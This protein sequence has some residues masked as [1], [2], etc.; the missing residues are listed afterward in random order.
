LPSAALGII[1]VLALL[2]F[3]LNSAWLVAIG[4]LAGLVRSIAW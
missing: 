1:A 3:E 4:A 2:I